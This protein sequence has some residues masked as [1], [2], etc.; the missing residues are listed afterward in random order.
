MRSYLVTGF[1]MLLACHDEDTYEA[2]LTLSQEL[3][4]D[5]RCPDEVQLETWEDEPVLSSTLRD[6]EII[7]YSP[8][9]WYRAEA[10]AAP[11]VVESTANDGGAS[12]DDASVPAHAPDGGDETPDDDGA[13]GDEAHQVRCRSIG[14]LD[15]ERARARSEWRNDG[16]PSDDILCTPT[17]LILFRVSLDVAGCRAPDQLWMPPGLRATALVAEDA[18]ARHFC[19]YDAIVE[20][21]GGGGCGG[22]LMPIGG[23]GTL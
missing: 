18:R 20:R 19:D 21:E 8:L 12:G 1:L 6:D 7:V 14:S 4:L 10:I 2:T 11:N 22:P 17:D 23:L 13:M 9:C 5:E 16:Y 15:D 3:S